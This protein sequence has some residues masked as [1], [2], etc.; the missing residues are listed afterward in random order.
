MTVWFISDTHFGHDRIRELA[1]RNCFANVDEMDEALIAN[2]NAMVQSGDTIWHLGDFGFGDKDKLRAIFL[3][4]NGDKHLIEG[5][6]DKQVVKQLPWASIHKFKTVTVDHMSVF[7]CHYAMREWPG[8]FHKHIH[9]YGHSHGKLLGTSR[10][11]DAG[12]DAQARYRAIREGRAIVASD[13][14]PFSIGEALNE[15]ITRPL[16]ARPV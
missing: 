3:R 4:L 1:Q 13:Y 12:V 7:L 9:F 10:S 8:F 11:D 2:W 5:N 15:M 14:R 6:H 16:M